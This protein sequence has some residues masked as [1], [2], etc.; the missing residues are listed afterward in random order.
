ME[1]LEMMWLSGGIGFGVQSVVA[2]MVQPWSLRGIFN[3]YLQFY[4][5]DN[6]PLYNGSHA[7][8]WN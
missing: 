4:A 1:T 7:R 6:K 3:G 5:E 8:Q 2:S